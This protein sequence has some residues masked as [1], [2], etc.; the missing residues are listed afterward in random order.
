V[1]RE[2]LRRAE[3]ALGADHAR[4]TLRQRTD[5][6]VL[7]LTYDREIDEA[8]FLPQFSSAEGR[9]L[10]LQRALELGRQ[11]RY[12][13]FLT[14]TSASSGETTS[15]SRSGWRNT[16]RPWRYPFVPETEHTVLGLGTSYGEL[17]FPATRYACTGTRNFLHCTGT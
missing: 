1:Y 5:V 16:T 9:N 3:A 14:T 11:Y 2:A 4:T 15:C 13:S 7:L 8:I 6:D 12:S 17:S 10:L